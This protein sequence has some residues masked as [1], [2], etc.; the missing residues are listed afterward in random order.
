MAFE[1]YVFIVVPTVAFQETLR[2]YDPQWTHTLKQRQ[3]IYNVKMHKPTKVM[4]KVLQLD[5]VCGIYSR[6]AVNFW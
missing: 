3:R 2:T 5:V 1:I 4:N 6:D